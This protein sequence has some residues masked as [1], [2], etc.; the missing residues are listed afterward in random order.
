MPL[1][2]KK[3]LEPEGE[4]GVWEVLETEAWFRRQLRLSEPEA[5]QLARIKGRRRLDWLAARQLVH[6]MSG[7]TER[8]PFWKDEYGKPHL[9]GAD[10]MISISHSGNV[11]AAI[12]SPLSV[13][14]DIQHP[15][16]KIYRLAPKFLRPGELDSLAEGDNR[17]GHLHVY[18]GAKEALYKA[19][20]R[21]KLDFRTHIGLEPFP[22]PP[23][24]GHTRGW[25]RKNDYEGQF[26]VHYGPFRGYML[27][28]VVEE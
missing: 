15:V 19:Y 8:G 13:G 21:R 5:A 20:G 23:V 6:I 14:I 10:W 17:L 24:Q 3:P 27:V 1:I 7:R 25:V 22:Y 28:Y 18:W 2:Y 16:A 11:A 4:L 26:G 9:E 12:A